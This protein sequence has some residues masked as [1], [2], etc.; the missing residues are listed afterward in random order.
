[1]FSL[2]LIIM[3]WSYCPQIV[4]SPA[5]VI[6]TALHIRMS[7][8]YFPCPT[9]HLYLPP[10]L[11]LISMALSLLKE[12]LF[13][14]KATQTMNSKTFRL[15]SDP[16]GIDRNFSKRLI[17]NGCDWYFIIPSSPFIILLAF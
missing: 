4:P 16:A 14:S 8:A 12:T 17:R 9:A 2:H 10:S 7:N 13:S 1:M 15:V 6:R 5:L 3:T 11:S